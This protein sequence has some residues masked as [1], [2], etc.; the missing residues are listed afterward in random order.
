MAWYQDEFFFA[1]LRAMASMLARGGG[2]YHFLYGEDA[3]RYA[4]SIAGFRRNRIVCT[5]HQP[6]A[7]FERVI[8]STAHLRRLHGVVVLASN[9]APYF[10]ALVGK[11]KVFLVPHGVDTRF[12]RP[13]VTRPKTTTCLF[14]GQWLRDFAMLAEVIQLVRAKDRGIHFEVVTK[15]EHHHQ[16][17]GLEGVNLRSALPE[18]DLL[19]LYQTS[20]LLVLPLLDCAAN[21]AVL[22]AMAC[23]L[24]IVATG[25]GGIGDYLDDGCSCLVPPGNSPRMADAIVGLVQDDPKRESLGRGARMKSLEF[26]WAVVASRLL[27]VY[28]HLG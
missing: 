22:E 15:P 25:V 13:P 8:R 24:P 17:A 19:A 11:E 20:A 2:I 4:G 14:V 16:L 27:E 23:G 28:E 7:V 3:Y 6:P 10:R 21:N 5:Y 26:D 18:D 1:E 9:Q 12:F